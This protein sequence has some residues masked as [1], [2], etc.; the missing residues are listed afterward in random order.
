VIVKHANPCGVAVGVAPG[1]AYELA[2]ATDPT[3]AF[4]GIIA[5][6]VKL[7][8]ATARA[9]LDRQ[10]VEVL[11]APDYDEGALAC[12]RKKA[13][14]RVLRIPGA[15]PSPGFIDVKRVGSGLLMQTA[16]DRVVTRDGLKVVTK[17]APTEAQF[18]DLLFA[19]KVAKFV[20]SNAIVYANDQR[21]T[22]VGA[23]QMSRVYSARI[24]GIKADDAG[25][26]VPG[27]VMASDAFF[28]F[29]DGID[30]AAD[31]GIVAV[32]QPGGSMR[33]AEVIAA[34]DERG[35]AMVFTGVRHFRH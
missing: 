24:A 15:P 29:R 7:D 16:D 20:K 1:D 2:Y 26:G 5:F 13:N 33:D 9:I 23:G 30:A 21:T 18:A 11:I 22:G 17:L 32:I 27:S 34:A 12:A 14:V 8:A 25:L 35:L 28:P 31:A 10:F 19:W 6:N 3:S 4:G